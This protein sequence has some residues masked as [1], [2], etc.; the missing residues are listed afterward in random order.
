MRRVLPNFVR[1]SGLGQS[2]FVVDHSHLVAQL[3]RWHRELPRVAVR[4]AVKC[5]PD[6]KLLKT[7]ARA[8]CGFDCATPSEIRAALA[9]G[10]P[11][12]DVVYAHTRKSPL[13]LR[14]ANRLG[15]RL[16]TFDSH[17]ELLKLWAIHPRAEL[18]LRL[19]VDDATAQCP[20]GNKFGARLD[21]AHGLLDHA[22]RLG[23]SV[24]GVSFHVGSG[25]RD[26]AS[27]PRALEQASQI[28]SMRPS[29]GLC[30]AETRSMDTLDIGGGFPGGESAARAAAAFATLCTPLRA[31][32]DRLFPPSRGVRLLAEPGRF[33]AAGS[34]TLLCSVIGV[35]R[36][37]CFVSDSVYGSFNCIHND[38]SKPEPV[39]V[40]RSLRHPS[41]GGES[42]LR[43]TALGGERCSPTGMLQ[44]TVFGQTCDGL[45]VVHER[46]DLPVDLRLGDA[47]L[48][49]DMG[50]YTVCASSRF[51]GFPRPVPLHLYGE[52][53]REWGQ[54]V[55]AARQ[56]RA[57]P[58][59]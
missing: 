43:V 24:A 31:S 6:P 29:G 36:R 42:L 18:L 17:D 48:Y 50:A 16:T 8:G 57:S 54:I 11:A 12:G 3:D 41:E 27:F 51:N 28:F 39:A 32:L 20:L 52:E 15:V 34:H 44:T 26:P 30:A 5:N 14:A 4:Y 25:C 7:L 40:W 35:D 59:C 53:G 13:D 56:Q 47:L 37:G 45:D 55:D 38:H 33:F 23:L 58:G 49:P 2:L 46:L 22:W 19:H 1:R 9:A 21:E 10:C